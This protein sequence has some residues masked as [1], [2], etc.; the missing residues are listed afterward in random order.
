M[1]AA[2][3]VDAVLAS[4]VRLI[5]EIKRR[6]AAGDDL[7]AGRSAAELV[8]LYEDA[9]APCLSVVT[10]R[11]FGG[12]AALLDDVLR[13]TDRPVLQKDF[14]TRRAQLDR[15]AAAGVCAVLLTAQLLR[16]ESLEILVEHALGVGLTPFVEVISAEEIA[17]VP[18]AGE[19]AIAVNN[20]DIRDQERGSARLGRSLEL[21]HEVLATG[22]P[23]AVSASGIDSRDD[24]DRLLGAGYGGLLVGSS[25]LAGSLASSL[26]AAPPIGAE[27]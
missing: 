14:F 8:R 17:S 23:L 26:T 22:T 9:G 16:R 4:E 27:R 7:T 24:V 19:C 12:D 20:K 10:G 25:L 1:S 13:A 15:A 18:R 3:F 11:W 6:S 2:P 21:V 5:M